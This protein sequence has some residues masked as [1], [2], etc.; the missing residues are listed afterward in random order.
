[1]SRTPTIARQPVIKTALFMRWFV[2]LLVAFDLLSA[3][4][5]AHAH[6]MGP[7]MLLPHTHQEAHRE[8][9]ADHVDLDVHSEWSHAEEVVH[10]TLGHSNAA[11]RA[12]D[13]RVDVTPS[14]DLIVSRV[15]EI[16]LRPCDDSSAAMPGTPAVDHIPIPSRCTLRPEGRAPP[17]LHS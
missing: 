16:V 11:L 6:D 10:E 14:L 4:L 5:H 3:P 13:A 15:W 17:L 12:S 8:V 2:L 9:H 1:M 7:D